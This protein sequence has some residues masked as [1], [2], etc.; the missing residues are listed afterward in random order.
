MRSL[1]L[2]FTKQLQKDWYQKFGTST[3]TAWFEANEQYVALYALLSKLARSTGYSSGCSQLACL[4]WSSLH[5][6]EIFHFHLNLFSFC[7]RSCLQL[8]TQQSCG[9]KMLYLQELKMTGQI[10]VVLFQLVCIKNHNFR[11]WE[12][13]CFF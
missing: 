11:T 12:T 7:I 10:L 13:G 3:S 1:H 9:E 4:V 8:C 2:L 5:Q 6:Y